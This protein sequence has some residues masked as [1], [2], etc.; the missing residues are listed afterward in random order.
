MSVLTVTIPGILRGKARPRVTKAGH[1][2]TPAATVSAEAWVRQCTLDQVGQPCLDGALSVQ[3]AVASGVP[4]SWSKKK[5]S[6]ALNNAVRPT[7]KPDID[8]LIKTIGDALNGIMWR[9][10]SQI[11][12]L[13][14]RKFYATEPFT[15][16]TVEAL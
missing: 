7:G 6:A 4:P 10:D 16:L 1:A 8:N 5:R 3:I 12:M 14:A 13:Q 9:D 11:V 15:V 2:Y